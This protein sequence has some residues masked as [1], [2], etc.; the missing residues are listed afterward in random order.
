MGNWVSKKR[1][2]I[3]WNPTKTEATDESF[4]VGTYSGTEEGQGEKGTSQ[5]HSLILE[6]VGNNGHMSE[7]CKPGEKV[8]F[9]GS[10]VLD[11]TIAECISGERMKI[12]YLGKTK[13]KDGKGSYHNWDV[14]VD[15]STDAKSQDNGPNPPKGSAKKQ[16]APAE[17]LLQDDAEADPFA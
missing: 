3:F 4:I 17:A 5:V 9:W 13:T 7:S 16:E 1:A 15:T 10:K 2:G 11:D 8:A 12:L 6:E 14:L